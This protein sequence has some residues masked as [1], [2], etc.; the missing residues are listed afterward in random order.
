MVKGTFIV[1][2]DIQWHAV[3]LV[4]VKALLAGLAAISADQLAGQP[5]AHTLRLVGP[6]AALGAEHPAGNSALLSSSQVP[7]L[8]VKAA[9]V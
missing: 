5:V 1:R 4:V 3:L 6:L 8:F 2:K 7:H 9:S